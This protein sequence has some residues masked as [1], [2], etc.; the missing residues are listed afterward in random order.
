MSTQ[1]NDLVIR[2]NNEQIYYMPETLV[3]SD[4]L[5]EYKK[6]AVTSG[7][8]QVRT[9]VARDLTTLVGKVKF[10][11]PATV[12]SEALKTQWKT[13]LEGN[14]IQLIGPALASKPYF[15]TP[16]ADFLPIKTGRG[17]DGA[18]IETLKDAGVSVVGN[19][20]AGN[21]IITGEVVTTYKTDSAGNADISFTF[22]NYV[23]TASQVREYFYINYVKRFSQDRLTTGDTIGT[24]A[25]VNENTV[26][27]YSKS[28]YQDL[29]GVEFVLLEAGAEALGFFVD[30][31]IITIDKALG[32]ITVSMRTPL[33]TQYRENATAMQVTFDTNR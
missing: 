21:T 22:L 13:N 20:T 18:E 6:R 15:N 24:R 3:Y 26:I 2:V 28:L 27:T 5:G 25:M 9:D 7:G 8:G 10:S 19:N 4:G 29:S 1:L 16:F 30:N 14:S 33:V 11:M 31:L 32:R 17:F 23:D 12:E